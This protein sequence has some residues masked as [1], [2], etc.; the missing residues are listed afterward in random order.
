[1]FITIATIKINLTWDKYLIIFSKH[2]PA[3]IEFLQAAIPK[4]LMKVIKE[5]CIHKQS[6]DQSRLKEIE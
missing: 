3:S 2:S 1:M 5:L 4:Y 6:K